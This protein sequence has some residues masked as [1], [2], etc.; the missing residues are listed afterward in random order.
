MGYCSY[1]LS[2][3]LP[4]PSNSNCECLQA[5]SSYRPK[6]HKNLLDR[7]NLP[8]CPYWRDRRTVRSLFTY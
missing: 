6:R 4:I 5:T 2:L 7:F 1:K 3:Q 8:I